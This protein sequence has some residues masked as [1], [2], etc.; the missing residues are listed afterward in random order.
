MN[1]PLMT[2]YGRSPPPKSLSD[3]PSVVNDHVPNSWG[4]GQ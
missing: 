2:P 4:V 3:L 1:L